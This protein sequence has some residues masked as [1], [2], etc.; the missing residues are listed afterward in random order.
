[1]T[2]ITILDGG[3][4]QE[5]V[6][7]IG[8]VPSGLWS[9]EIMNQRPDLVRAVH[10]D[11]F[12]AGAE[13][14]TANSYT[15]HRDRLK[16]AGLE[17]QFERLH[18]LA[19]DIAC[20]SRDAFGSGLVAGALGPLGW[21]YSH[22][23]APPI[24]QAAELYSE[25]CRIQVDYVDVFLI[26]TIASVEQAEAA[27]QGALGHGKPVWIGLTVDD[28]DGSKL[29][30]GESLATALAAIRKLGPQALLLNCSVPEAVTRGLSVL[31][32]AGIPTGAY[33]NGF[34]GISA[35]FQ[36]KG[37][38]V[39]R[40]AT[41]ENFTPDVYADHAGKWVELG[42]TMIGGCCE[43]GPAHIKELARRYSGNPGA[44]PKSTSDAA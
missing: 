32:D 12:A 43:V 22:D 7:R 35:A 1:M 25:I 24:E 42:A 33:A 11:F 2:E 31:G 18:H 38:N 19:C 4:G 27:L 13:V 15:L 28:G 30:S 14:A 44:G 39:S 8:H 29:R 20:R 5:L 6:R 23:G 3:M 34:T 17:D 41:R 10:D 40:L 9:G 37:S 21:S 36:K 16:P 26:E